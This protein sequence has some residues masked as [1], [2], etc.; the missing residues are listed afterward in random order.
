ALCLY[1][2]IAVDVLC[3][4]LNHHRILLIRA[5]KKSTSRA[6]LKNDDTPLYKARRRAKLIYQPKV[7]HAMFQF[8]LSTNLPDC[9]SISC[10]SY[11]YPCRISSNFNLNWNIRKREERGR[12]Q[13]RN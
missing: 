2:Y 5:I 9:V 13:T 7:L 4:S 6:H 3:L 11:G 10:K 12:W 1:R 8:P